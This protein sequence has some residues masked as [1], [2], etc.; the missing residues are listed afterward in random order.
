[1]QALGFALREEAVRQTLTADVLKSSA[2]EGEFL[3]KEE[4]RSSIARRLGMEAAGLPSAD[5]H[6]EGVV[7]MTLD[8]TRKFGEPLTSERLLAWHASL[9]PTGRSGMRKILVGAWRDYQSGPMQV[10][11]GMEGRE[12][13]HY[14]APAA[15]RL[16]AEMKTFL[17]WFNGE[18]DIDPVLKA[19]LAHLWFVNIHPFDD[20]DGR[21]ARAIADMSLARSENTPQRFYSMAAQIRLEQTAYYDMLESTQKA[22]LDVTPW[23]ELFRGFVDRAFK[24]A[25]KTLSS[26]LRKAEFWRTHATTPL[27]DRQRDMINRLLDGFEGKL[28]SSKWATIEKC[29]ADTA[30]RDIA[31]LV[32]R[33]LLWKN[34]GGGRSTS[35]S[36]ATDAAE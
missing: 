10:V 20:G 19:A 27:K 31:D 22:E 29:S 9:F 6:V 16:D 30:L 8:A 17:D 7:E 34:E 5:R 3:D 18:G 35:Y 26:V 23:M 4:V 11:S 12:R 1:M 28:S 33:G 15:A 2:I 21:I 14:Q 32:E 13:V 25:E 36:L 24:G